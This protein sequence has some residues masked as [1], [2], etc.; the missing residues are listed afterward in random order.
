MGETIC[1]GWYVSGILGSWGADVSAKNPTGAVLE[2]NF[3]RW[4]ILLFALTNGTTI[5]LRKSV[6]N[7]LD[8]AQDRY[9]FTGTQIVT[10]AFDTLCDAYV[11][12][13]RPDICFSMS[14]TRIP[15]HQHFSLFNRQHF[16]IVR[17]QLFFPF[18]IAVQNVSGRFLQ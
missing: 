4:G 16:F 8:V 15:N 17:Y 13:E 2:K 9:N 18:S 14:A 6:G 10:G 3:P 5:R 1:D 11:L 12:V 7:L